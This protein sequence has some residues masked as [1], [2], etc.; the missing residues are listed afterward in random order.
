MS[1]PASTINVAIVCRS[2]WHEPVFPVSA[3]VM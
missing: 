3:A 1:H 2:V